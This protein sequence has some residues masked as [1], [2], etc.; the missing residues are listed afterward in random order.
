MPN[1]E[2]KEKIYQFVN[3]AIQFNKHHNIFQRTSA[4]EVLKKDI[5]E[6][7]QIN[8]YISKKDTVLDIGSGGGFPGVVIA[9]SNPKTQTHL[10]ESNQKKAYFLKQIKHDLFLDNLIVHNQRIE[11]HNNLGEF[12][13][14]T[15]RAFATIEKILTLSEN[16]LL[17]SGKYVLFK[18]T[19][20]KIEE[21]LTSL[22]T[23]KF[24][25]E[26]IEQDNKE[27]ERHL[28]VIKKHE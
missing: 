21:E 26:I 1:P 12:S 19:K 13:L 15:A 6:S 9:I 10:V 3:K 18:G 2:H 5:E 7:L 20:N 25:Y 23:N 14:I 27:K 17:Q 22:N 11:P 4:E 8:P 16:N 28:V 24:K